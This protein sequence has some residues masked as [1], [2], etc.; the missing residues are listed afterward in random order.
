MVLTA[1]VFLVASFVFG[2]F[3]YRKIS[4]QESVIDVGDI[5][6]EYSIDED[7][8]DAV[9]EFYSRKAGK[10]STIIEQPAL[11]TDPSI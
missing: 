2:F 3:L 4:R 11:F 10:S 8:V 1:V 7:R 9:L 5:K 6:H